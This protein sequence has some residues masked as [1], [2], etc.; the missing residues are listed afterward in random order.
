MLV[1]CL[2]SGGA[3]GGGI[4]R[5]RK[6]L[7]LLLLQAR[8]SGGVRS[9]GGLRLRDVRAERVVPG[10]RVGVARICPRTLG[11]T[12]QDE[13]HGTKDERRPYLRGAGALREFLSIDFVTVPRLAYGH[14]LF[15]ACTG[16]FTVL[17]ATGQARRTHQDGACGETG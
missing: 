13:C 5:L 3:L 9:I 12:G 6:L 14:S 2:K 10:S 15:P 11:T 1:S 8:R 7:G 4:T 16:A 17:R